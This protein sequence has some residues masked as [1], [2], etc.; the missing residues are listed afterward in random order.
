LS[1][2]GGGYGYRLWIQDFRGVLAGEKAPPLSFQDFPTQEQAFAE[3]QR[4]RAA[5]NS[6]ELL[7]T[8]T[9]VPSVKQKR[10]GRRR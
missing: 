3:K 10:K 9:E 2:Q 8:V 7:L 5:A 6:P 4:I 1:D